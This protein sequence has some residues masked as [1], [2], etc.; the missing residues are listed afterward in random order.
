MQTWPLA[1]AGL[2]EAAFMQGVMMLGFVATLMV[3]SCALVYAIRK[4]RKESSQFWLACHAAWS[5]AYALYLLLFVNLNTYNYSFEEAMGLFE[6]IVSSPLTLA[7]L[8]LPGV[9][10]GLLLTLSAALRRHRQATA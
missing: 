1:D 5:I 2:A 7:V 3:L 9:W 8:L 4:G 10:H 6:W